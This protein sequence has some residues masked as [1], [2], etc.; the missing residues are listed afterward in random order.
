LGWE[1]QS[2]IKCVSRLTLHVGGDVAVAVERHADV[3][4]PEPFL[5][6][7]GVHALGEEQGG[8]GM[9]EVVEPNCRDLGVGDELLEM[10]RH[11]I[12]VQGAPVLPVNKN[13]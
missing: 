2:G 10:H 11:A 7:L 8:A 3:G 1:N 6:D 13:P 9:P 12:D 4:M 5:H